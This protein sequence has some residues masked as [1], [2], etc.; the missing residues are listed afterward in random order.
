MSDQSLLAMTAT[1]VVDRLRTGDITPHDLLDALEERIAS[2]DAKV[3][4]LPIL[5]FD[6]ARRHADKLAQLPISERGILAGLPM[7]IKDMIPVA[8]V[9][10]TKGSPILSEW[11]PDQSDLL[12]EAL[13]QRGAVIYA[14]SNVPEFGVGGNTFNEV[15]GSTRNPWDTRLSAAGSSGGAAAA[16]AAGMAWLAHGADMGGSLRTPASFCG[17]VGFRPSPGRVAATPTPAIDQTLAVEGPMARNVEDA[18]LLLDAMSGEDWRDPLSLPHCGPSFLQAARTEAPPARVAWSADLGITPVEP[19]VAAVCRRAVLGF[20]SLGAT[21]EE[22][23]PDFSEAHECFGVLRAAAFA[24]AHAANIA[25]HRDKLNPEIV[26]NVEQGLALTGAV[27]ARAQ[28]QRAVLY[29]R[30]KAFFSTFD[31]LVTPAAITPPFPVEQRTVETC[32]GQH[33][34]NYFAWLSITYAITL[35]CCP[36]ISIPVGLTSA[37]TPV[38]LQI[39]GPPR[40]ERALLS[41]A[42]MLEEELAVS[43]V[44]PID[45]R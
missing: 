42:R 10:C 18:A 26:W 31:L 5:C 37:G 41:A 32:G 28:I 24:T 19:E 16:L 8:G 17:V 2:V 34:D 40:G 33:F 3:N 30:A 9:R 21:V 1:A 27:L 4:A 22:A 36:A 6:R 45:P 29:D 15:L 38:G 35:V 44:T 11:I 14:K 20:E 23:H 39:V 25:N 12:V 43:P 13:E 7:P